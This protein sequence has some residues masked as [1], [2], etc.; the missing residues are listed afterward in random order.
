[1]SQREHHIFNPALECID[2]EQL[3]KLQGERLAATV[4]VTLLPALPAKSAGWRVTATIPLTDIIAVREVTLLP[5]ASVTTQRTH[6][7]LLALLSV[8]VYSADLVELLRQF[9]PSSESCH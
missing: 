6:R 4:K 7:P 2:R 8:A 9:S 1:M 3:R 5:D